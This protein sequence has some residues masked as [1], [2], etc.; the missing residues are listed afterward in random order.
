MSFFSPP[1]NP[2]PAEFPLPPVDALGNPIYISQRVRI[3]MVP[4][5]LTHDLPAEDVA[6]LKSIEGKAMSILEIDAYGY[7]WPGEEDP[8][9]SV[10]PSEVI[11]LTTD[12]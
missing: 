5:W 8:W 1:S 9:F 10:R 2:L 12:Q 11:A 6:R 4:E 7:V 3:S